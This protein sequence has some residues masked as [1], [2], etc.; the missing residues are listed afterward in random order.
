MLAIVVARKARQYL[1]YNVANLD[2]NLEHAFA[3]ALETWRE[4]YVAFMI[5]LDRT[6]AP[7]QRARVLANLRRYTEDFE[8]LAA[9]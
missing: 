1:P 7:E 4:Q 6:L 2:L 3:A 8:A 5:E 9:R